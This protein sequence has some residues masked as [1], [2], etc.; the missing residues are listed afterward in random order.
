MQNPTEEQSRLRAH[1][2]WEAA[3][4]PE[5]QQDQF[6]FEA[7]RELTQRDSWLDQ[8]EKSGTFTE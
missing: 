8:D 2:L 6:W 7:G 3:S 5:G 4:R 1:V